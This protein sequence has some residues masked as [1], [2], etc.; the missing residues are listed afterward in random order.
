MS[1]KRGKGPDRNTDNSRILNLKIAFTSR[2]FTLI[3][4][5]CCN[6]KNRERRFWPCHEPVSM[7][8]RTSDLWIPRSDALLLSHR[9][10]GERGLTE[11]IWQA[12][13]RQIARKS[14]RPKPESCCPKFMSPKILSRVARNFIECLNLKKSNILSKS[15]GISS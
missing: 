2:T 13:L 9:L 14:S 7:R 5:L 10:Y 1:Y 15:Q 4:N 3:L 6:A 8:N 11:F 12:G